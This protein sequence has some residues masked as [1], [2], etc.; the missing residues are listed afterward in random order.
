MSVVANVAINVD[1][2]DAV[3]KLRQVQSQALSTEKAFEGINRTAS[4][5]RGALAG[6]GIAGLI[7]QTTRAAASFNDLQLRLKLLTSQY[8]ETARAQEFVAKSARTFG[9][10]TREAT[11]GVANIFARLRPLGVSLK[12]IETT[13]TGFNTVARLSGVGAAE[14][15]SAFTQ[16]AQ[17]LGS[18]RLQGD[19]F[20]SIAEQVPGLLVAISQ[21]TGVA[22]GELKEYAAQGKLTSETVIAALGRVEREGAS[23]IAQI[24]KDS[25][26][27][28][29]KD[30]QNAADDLSIAIG[31]E[32]LPV[33]TPL[34][35][36]VTKLIR[37][38]AELPQPVKSVITELVKFAAQ[39]FLVSKAIQGIIALRAAFTATLSSFATTTAA[40]GVAATTSS[41]AFALYTANTKTLQ[42]AA[43][44][45]TPVLA[46]L[47]GILAN[48]AAIGVIT[49]GINL[50]VTGLQEAL[51]AAAEVRRLRGERAAGGAAAIFGGS[52]TAEQ[53]AT[54][55]KSLEAIRKEQQKLRSGGVIAKQTLLGPLAP[56]AGVPTTAQAGARRPVLQERARRAEA[57][58]ALPTRAEAAIGNGPIGGGAGGG[59]EGGAKGGGKTAADQS[60]EE[61]KRLQ[62]RIRGL[63]IET[64]L[65]Q[66]LSIIKSQIADAENAGNKE[67]AIKL[68]GE[69]QAKQIIS[70]LQ[71][72][73]FGVTDQRERLA[74]ITK[75]AAELDAVNTETAIELERQRLDVIKEQNAEF[76]KRAGL[77]VQDRLPG[78]AGA[79]DLGL[80][81]LRVSEGEAKINDLKQQLKELSDP[82]NVALNGATAIGDAFST[83]FTDVITGA[84]SAQQ[85]L[86]EVFKKIADAFIEAATQIIAKQI[87]LITFQTILNALGGGGGFSFGGATEGLGAKVFGSA[88]STFGEGAFTTARL[89]ADGGF[90][91]GP[92]NAV[93]GEG[94]QP[95]YVIP[96]SKMSAAMTRYAAGNR[97]A[98]VIPSGGEQGGSTALTTAPMEPID[99]RYSVDRINNVDYVT[100]DQFQRGLAQAA[101][102]GAVQGERRALRTLSNSPANRRRVGLG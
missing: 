59:A 46:G 21:E 39:A 100:N 69:S 95:E 40:T 7:V 5:L 74:I 52:A 78:G 97:G 102:Q 90:V 6:V 94:G 20:R 14:S 18:G 16:L 8:G 64:Q 9:L 88:S 54:A 85:A 26:V 31:N 41:R 29:F 19:E 11:A 34:I 28:K 23:K 44:T 96:A 89:F 42:A 50:I 72:T 10:S 51:A 79:F 73:L 25:D 30:F 15:A 70:D 93:I 37:A 27:Q 49:I 56:L 32:L 61:E 1:S 36:E 83:A 65:T 24:I 66:Q 17:A 92:T 47:R 60:A 62:E 98:S 91:T 43:A 53:K 57:I 55:A 33:V 63:Q 12:D 68:R 76:F 45:T 22:A 86:S 35:Q 99:V 67:L 87:A 80:P 75:T 58:L 101:Q 2:R 81:D 77:T 48:L 82:I 3:S 84:K 38:I 13:F 71:K 4:G